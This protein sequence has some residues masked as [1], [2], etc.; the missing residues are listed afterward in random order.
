MG[1]IGGILYPLSIGFPATLMAPVAFLQ[2]PLRWLQAISRTHAT[3]S[4]APNFAYDLCTAKITPEQ[5]EGL[6][7]SSLRIVF[8]GVLTYSLADS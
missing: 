4:V 6:D 2:R 1:L 5:M 8:N 7:L 3:V